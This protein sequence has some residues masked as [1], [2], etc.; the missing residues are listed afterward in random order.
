MRGAYYYLDEMKRP[1]EATGDD[2]RVKRL[3]ADNELRKVAFDDIG[4]VSVSTV[5]LI[6]DHS[7]NGTPLL[8]ETLVFDGPHDGWMDR[9][10][11]WQHAETG[12]ARVVERLRA[13]LTPYPNDASAGDL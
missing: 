6:I 3:W 1:V 2:P 9:Y 4:E 13:G 5:F 10:T 11:S 8:F 7:F 12:H